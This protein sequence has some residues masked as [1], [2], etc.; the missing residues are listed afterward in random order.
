MT[1]SALVSFESNG[2]GTFGKGTAAGSL[3][4][5]SLSGYQEFILIGATLFGFIPLS[6]IGG[7]SIL[8]DFSFY[9]LRLMLLFF[10]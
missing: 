7:A 3:S 9:E 4:L 1:F 8:I 10:F 5:I 2:D 6:S